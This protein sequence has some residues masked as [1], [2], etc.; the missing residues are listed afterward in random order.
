MIIF[1]VILPG[2]TPVFS[3]FGE[4]PRFFCS[5]RQKTEELVIRKDCVQDHIVSVGPSNVWD[6]LQEKVG[7]CNVLY[8]TLII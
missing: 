2:T 8:P 7:R 6:L 3:C 5:L 4:H 1:E